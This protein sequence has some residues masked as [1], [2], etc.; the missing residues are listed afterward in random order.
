MW[1]SVY[2][3]RVVWSYDH[4][5]YAYQNTLPHGTS[6]LFKISIVKDRLLQFYNLKS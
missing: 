4:D 2:I 5:E 3:F 1:D 6:F